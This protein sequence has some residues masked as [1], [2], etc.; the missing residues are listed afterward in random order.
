MSGVASA[1]EVR[2]YMRT[3]R[4]RGRT[5]SDRYASLL[6]LVL[7]VVIAGPVLVG[8]LS[9]V[10]REVDPSRASAG[11]ALLA[12]LLAGALS[13]ARMFGPVA[14]PAADAAWLLL[15][16][17]PR[18]GV[19]GRTAVILIGVSV[20]AGAALGVGLLAVLGTQ[21][22]TVLRLTAALAIGVATMVGGMSAAVS[23]QAFERWDTWLT[24]G[25]TVI[26]ISA[27]IAAFAG[28]GPGRQA[29][30][31]VVSA[32]PS[33]VM[34]VATAFVVAA[35]G[36]ALRAWTAL[37][38]IPARA[39]LEASTRTGHAAVAA[40]VM[41]LGAL[42][43]IAE[44]AHWRGRSLR[45]RPWPSGLGRAPALAVAWQE[46]RR[47]ARRPVRVALL[48]SSALLPV[49]VARATPDA[50]GGGL[51]AAVAVVL[52]A[53]ALTAAAAVTSG[54]R[55]DGDNP[56]MARLLGAGPR[57][58]LAARAMAPALLGGGWLVAALA[59]LDAAGALPAGPW[60]LLGA[61]CGP[62]LAAG[63]L[64]M[65]RRRPVDHSMPVLDT[66]VGAFPTGP[67]LWALTGADVAV[68]GCAPALAALTGGPSAGL[69][70]AQA[71]SG[72]TVLG[73]YLGLR[74]R[75]H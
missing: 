39:V 2:A 24:G 10:P 47:L 36:L 25:I 48:A 20:L 62:A 75:R 42:T 17:L 68:L 14:L 59:A 13:A 41:D 73:L 6:G 44:D 4:P 50:A 40:V 16:P 34:A 46:W 28:L 37:G 12:L 11:V 35:A 21:D 53:G 33:A 32:P 31:S 15:S 60:W 58:L 8:A 45:S 22:Q 70:A 55:R 56:A 18:R 29:A 3:R 71:M 69:L 26:V 74:G 52:C 5:L 7:A 72:A 51:P 9:A 30:A 27:G 63:A 67:M 23:A 1:T 49:L 54:A 64:R 19:L 38:R 65:A 43:W 66:P 61:A 57:A